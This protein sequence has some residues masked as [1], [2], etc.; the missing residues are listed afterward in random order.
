MRRQYIVDKK[1]Q[2]TIVGYSVM[3]SLLTTLMHLTLSRISAV[4]TLPVSTSM[5]V[6]G[7]F[8]FAIFLL[9]LFF[10]NRL[11]GPL[12]RLSRHL[13]DAAKGQKLQKIY[14]RH[15]DFFT[16]LNEAY[17]E[18][19]DKSDQRGFTLMELMVV[20]GIL[21]LM[22]TMSITMVG[23]RERDSFRF[24]REVASMQDALVTARNAAVTK[25]QCAFV[26]RINA[27]TVNIATY[28]IPSPC[29]QTPL[30]APDFQQIVQFN[31]DTIV[32]AFVPGSPI[33]FRPTGGLTIDTPA[34][35]NISSSAGA[36][37]SNDFTVYPAIGQVRRM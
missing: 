37:L 13:R 20:V 4:R 22:A 16:D 24:K 30:P 5:A 18:Y 35:V 6:Y 7:V 12:Y 34:R 9:S 19:V 15:K 33:I 25:G 3:V 23:T 17:N 27:Q 29:T 11:A 14:F 32:G 8:Y 21:G 31:A 26:S 2:W 10:S 1:F 28:A 36:G